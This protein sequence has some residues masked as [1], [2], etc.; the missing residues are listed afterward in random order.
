MKYQITYANGLEFQLARGLISAGR[1]QTLSNWKT[2]EGVEKDY[3]RKLLDE[4]DVILA[5]YDAVLIADTSQDA[6]EEIE[7]DEDE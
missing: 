2:T 1:A 3:H 4:I 6:E 5:R 7:E